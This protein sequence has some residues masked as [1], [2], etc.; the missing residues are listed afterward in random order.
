MQKLGR[1]D[2]YTPTGAPQ[3]RSNCDPAIKHG[4]ADE[5]RG[6]PH[7]GG[8]I[9]T[10][11]RRVTINIT[12]DGVELDFNGFKGRTCDVMHKSIVKEMT[13][14]GVQVNPKASVERPKKETGQL[15]KM[16]Q[17]N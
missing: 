8:G 10:M 14:L 4:R 2:T 6:L 9:L 1:R 5:A 16:R 3:A 13:R 7:A 17:A 11:A 12:D 15:S